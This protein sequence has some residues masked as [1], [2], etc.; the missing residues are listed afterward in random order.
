MIGGTPE[1]ADRLLALVLDG[2]KTATASAL[3]DYEAGGE[4]DRTLDSWRHMHREFFSTYAA[5]D[6]GFAFDMPVV[7]ER[8]EVLYRR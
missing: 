1:Q 7:L 8:F 3:W 4:D 5:H 6:R 2:T